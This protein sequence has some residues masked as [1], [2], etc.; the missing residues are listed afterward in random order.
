MLSSSPAESEKFYSRD[1]FF[2]LTGQ[3]YEDL[4]IPMAPVGGG[5]RAA[6][7]CFSNGKP[8]VKGRGKSCQLDSLSLFPYKGRLRSPDVQ[9]PEV[10]KWL[11]THTPLDVVSVKVKA[12]LLPDFYHIHYTLTYRVPINLHLESGIL[13]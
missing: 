4:A 7:M 6:N 8:H 11:L 2:H 1:S 3:A 13:K 12:V 5:G 9:E 10:E